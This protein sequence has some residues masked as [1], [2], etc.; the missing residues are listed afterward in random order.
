MLDITKKEGCVLALGTFDGLHLGHKKVL[1]AGSGERLALLFNEHPQKKLSGRCPTAL[2][3]KR[4][5][6]KLLK[7]WGVT[8]VRVD[9]SEIAELSPQ[10]FFEQIIKKISPRGISVGFNYRFGK[11]AEGDVDELKT[12][13]DGSGIA[14]YVAPPQEIF[15]E[16]ISSTKIRELIKCGNMQKA[17]AML[18]RS[19]CYDFTVVHGD[20]RGRTIGSPTINQFFDEGFTV[21]EFGV[22]ASKTEVDG[23]IYPSVTNIGVRP[24]VGSSKERSETNIIGFEGDLYGKNIT[25]ML[26][27]KIRDEKKFSSVEELRDRINSDKLLSLNGF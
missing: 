12:L 7:E 13:C 24:T 1:T 11:N 21:P 5:E 26:G 17:N 20:K 6:E 18:G 19:F 8:P 25:V 10:L 4:T 22:Y 14:L 23:V 16:V 15:G 27:K 3:T 9:F 2:I